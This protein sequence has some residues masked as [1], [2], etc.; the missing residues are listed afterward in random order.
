MVERIGDEELQGYQVG[1]VDTDNSTGLDGIEI[2]MNS[3]RESQVE[4]PS[5]SAQ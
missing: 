4:K 3:Y 1:K 5:M 2:Q